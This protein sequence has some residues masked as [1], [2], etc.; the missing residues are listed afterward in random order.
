MFYTCIQRE[1]K[2]FLW[3]NYYRLPETHQRTILVYDPAL[4]LL[5]TYSGEMKT[6][7]HVKTCRES[8]TVLFWMTKNRKTVNGYTNCCTSKLW[9]ALPAIKEEATTQKLGWNHRGIMPHAASQ[10]CS[11]SLQR[12]HT[13]TPPHTRHSPRDRGWALEGGPDY[14]KGGTRSTSGEGI[15]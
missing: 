15:S 7:V 3:N 11:K 8:F 1:W 10:R 2:L 14:K 6:S 9:H 12:G 4:P 5:D 13:A